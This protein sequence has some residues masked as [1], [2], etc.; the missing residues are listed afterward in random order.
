MPALDQNDI[1]GAQHEVQRLLGRCILRLQQYEHL[2]KAML[3]VNKLSGTSETLPLAL[4]NRRA[5]ISGK[6]MG[7]LVSRLMAE[8]VMRE[9]AEAPADTT[10]SRSDSCFLT[11]R[12][13]L[14]LPD[15]SHAALQT[16]LRELV[17]LRNM[18][19][20]GFIERHDI[21]T[22][23][24][25]LQAQDAL[26]S[27]YTKIDQHL[28]QLRTFAENMDETRR[29]FAELMQSPEFH[30][31]VV[32]GVAPDGQILWPIA[33]IVSALRQA[34]RERPIDGWVN[35][36]TAVRWVSEHHPEQTPKK[37]GCARWRHVIHESGQFELRRFTHNGQFGAWLRERVSS[38]G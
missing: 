21:W 29:A 16:E 33:G 7:M 38:T 32:N 34:C 31:L 2:L 24:G 11:V 8:Y 17:R 37:Y 35:L 4:D 26:R 30:E 22:I 28:Q 1:V 27:S 9:G 6:T 20:H 36:D 19:V 10:D 3:A 15:E 25:C 18:L 23:D 13:Q 12:T 5:E 14:N